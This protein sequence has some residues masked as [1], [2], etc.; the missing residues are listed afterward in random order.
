MRWVLRKAEM[1]RKTTQRLEVGHPDCA[2][3]GFGG[4]KL[5]RNTPHSSS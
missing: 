3:I 2:A 5:A 1:A 4:T